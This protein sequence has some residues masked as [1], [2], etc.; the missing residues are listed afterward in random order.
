MSDGQVVSVAAAVM[1]DVKATIKVQ[2]LNGD[3]AEVAS[4]DAKFPSDATYP[5][6]A[7]Q[8]SRQ[9]WTRVVE[10]GGVA[11]ETKN[12]DEPLDFI[13]FTSILRVRPVFSKVVTADRVPGRIIM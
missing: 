9:F 5:E 8:L 10:L 12:L 3:W 7:G 13:P 1:V 2:L 6:I 11:A 4:M